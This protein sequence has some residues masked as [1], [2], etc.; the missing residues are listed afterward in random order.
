MAYTITLSEAFLVT[1]YFQAALQT[2]STPAKY[3]T[4]PGTMQLA[5][6]TSPSSLTCHS[7]VRIASGFGRIRQCQLIL[8][9]R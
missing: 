3:L 5:M 2:M 8:H 9:P 6:Q 1:F 7:L 4:E